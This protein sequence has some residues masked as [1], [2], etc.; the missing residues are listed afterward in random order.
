[1]SVQIGEIHKIG[2]L[3]WNGA[4]ELIVGEFPERAQMNELAYTSERAT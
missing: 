4:S 2:E 3:S 1:M